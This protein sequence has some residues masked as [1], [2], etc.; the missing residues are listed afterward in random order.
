MERS[1]DVKAVKAQKAELLVPSTPSFTS[2]MNRNQH[3]NQLPECEELHSKEVRMTG[4]VEKI[5]E[6]SS[7]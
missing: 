6:K 1:S 4:T 5:N 7:S 2:I 3:A